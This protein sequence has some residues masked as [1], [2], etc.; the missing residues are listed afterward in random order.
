MQGLSNEILAQEAEI[1]EDRQCLR[2]SY[3]P[4]YSSS[5]SDLR[6]TKGD[7]FS[8]DLFDSGGMDTH[9]AVNRSLL[10]ALLIGEEVCCKGED[11]MDCCKGM[12]VHVIVCLCSR[13]EEKAPCHWRDLN[14]LPADCEPGV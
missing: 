9:V 10:R 14:S 1:D 8:Y 6:R 12:C 3:H 5:L 2:V 11:K 7:S 13:E 4:F